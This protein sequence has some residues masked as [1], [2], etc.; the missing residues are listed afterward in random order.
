M[1]Q[2]QG[3]APRISATLHEETDHLLGERLLCESE[4]RFRALVEVS[5]D[6]IVAI[7]RRG[8]I[9][10][11]NPAAEELFQMRQEEAVGCTADC[12][13]PEEYRQRH[14]RARDAYFGTGKSGGLLGG[15]IETAALRA[16][17]QVFPIELSLS[18]GQYDGEPFVLAIIRDITDRKLTEEARQKARDEL[19]TEVDRQTAQLSA[20]NETL[21]RQ[22]AHREKVEEALRA[23]EKRYRQLLAAVTTYRYSV[24]V[25]RGRSI[26]TEHSEGCLKA[27]G[28]S[29]D[30]YAAD[31]GLWID[32]V[33]PDDQDSVLAHAADVLDG[34]T[35]PP[36][37]HRIRH[38][39]GS[40][41]WVRDTIVPHYDDSDELIRYDGLVEDVTERKRADERF[42]NLL[43]AAPDAMV[44]IQQDGT[45]V[46]VNA[47]T[48]RLF[49][50]TRDELLGQSV[51]ILVPKRLRHRH[52]EKRREYVANPLSI[53]ALS[54]DQE[55]LGLRK[56]GTEFPA[57]ITLSPLE[58]EEGLLISSA[59]R[60]ITERKRTERV[61][62]ENEAQLIAAQSI[63]EHL[64]PDAPPSLPGFDFAGSSYPA[65]FAAG[66]T[67]DYLTL[68]D[69]SVAVVIADV[70]GHGFA[71]ALLAA[72]T[73]ALLRSLANHHT[74]IDEILAIA[75][76]VLV[77]ETED[78]R[79][80]TL[81]LARIDP[82][83]RMLEYTSAGHP[84]GYLL[85]RDG[86]I[87]MHL[88]STAMP[89]GVLP[90]LEFPA[91]DPVPLEPGDL[92]VLLTDGVL[93]AASDSMEPFGVQR[94]LDLLRECQHLTASQIVEALHGAVREYVLPGN[95]IDD[96]TAVV[97]KVGP[98]AG[99]DHEI[100]HRVSDVHR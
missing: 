42:R 99:E 37:E 9:T 2:L 66:D 43:E 34:Q 90:E 1:A 70:S 48:E 22:I 55:L 30:D 45:I 62:Q 16:G 51:E 82:Q 95:V 63:Q 54:P 87:K 32:M 21:Q 71:P 23:S 65:D 89:L 93:E 27:T 20:A 3:N 94:T 84:S 76:S 100:A 75:N 10:V 15:T 72:S 12:L 25:D 88:E 49:G 44:I 81:L 57:E 91:C 50:Y 92:L 14:T 6:A 78:D 61:L 19:E 86:R 52:P 40:I 53:M 98:L 80:V 39:D 41:R 68:P 5:P 79:F 60:D 97:V 64:L 11:F 67:F 73:H 35:V 47:Q 13:M 4:E 7:D 58:T 77:Q 36:L 33:V 83:T 96:I 46:L 24:R 31:P 26:E 29:P 38:R 85:D 28:Y 69:G 74:E 18:A 59:I 8:I 56:D 17:G